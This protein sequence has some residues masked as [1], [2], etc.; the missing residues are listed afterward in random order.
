MKKFRR[1]FH[2]K[3]PIF[4]QKSPIFHQ[5]SPIFYLEP[6][7]KEEKSRMLHQNISSKLLKKF[8]LPLFR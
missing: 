4:R 3:S 2:Q 6:N 8:F 7:S 5:K 1:N